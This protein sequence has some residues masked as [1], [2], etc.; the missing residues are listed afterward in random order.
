MAGRVETEGRRVDASP[1]RVALPYGTTIEVN[2]DEYVEPG[3]LEQAQTMQILAGIVDPL[4]GQPALSVSEIRELLRLSVAA[5]SQ[6]LTSGV[7][8]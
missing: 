5:P 2:R 1:V 8:Q 3:P 6:S 7:L 4:T